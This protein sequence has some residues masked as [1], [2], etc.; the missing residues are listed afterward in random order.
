RIRL[1]HAEVGD[2]GRHAIAA[3]R[4]EVEPLDECA[5]TLAQHDEHLSHRGRDLRR[6]ART[7]KSYLRRVVGSDDGA[8]EIAEAV[9]LSGA[10]EADVD[11]ST[12]EPVA[13]H[14]G[15]RDHGVG[16]VREL[17]VADR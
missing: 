7:G 4:E 6:A 14:L 13:E 15:Y 17:P 16:G 10:E 2:D 9:D 8:V 5:R 3:R 11:A 12:L 1:E